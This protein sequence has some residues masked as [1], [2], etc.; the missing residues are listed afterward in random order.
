MLREWLETK[1]ASAGAQRANV[2]ECVSLLDSTARVLCEA[3]ADIRGLDAAAQDLQDS[4]ATAGM[5]GP[6]LAVGPGRSD[7]LSPARGR[8]P[9]VGS[10]HSG[11]GSGECKGTGRPRRRLLR[12]PAAAMLTGTE[13]RLFLAGRV[14]LS[15]DAVVQTLHAHASAFGARLEPSVFALSYAHRSAGRRSGTGTAVSW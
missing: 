8:S 12:A 3:D 2:R 4:R 14:E 10:S 6:F 9:S 1:E 15:E 7:P 11:D 13:Q 5:P